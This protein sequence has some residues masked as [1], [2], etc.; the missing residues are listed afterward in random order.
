MDLFETPHKLPLRV[1][2]LISRE[3][4]GYR[5]CTELRSQLETLGYT[6]DWDLDGI[7]Y[8][9]EPLIEISNDDIG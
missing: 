9:L 3:V 7:P 8:G 1:R 4:E 5:A 6:F 2:I